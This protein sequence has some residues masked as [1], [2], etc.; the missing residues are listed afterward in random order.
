MP[1]RL[2]RW[3]GRSA[4]QIMGSLLPDFG[5]IM[6]K[7]LSFVKLLLERKTWREERFGKPRGLKSARQRT[8]SEV[9]R[10]SEGLYRQIIMGQ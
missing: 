9:R 3:C 2:V 6:V 1:D 10:L 7:E 4:T 5:G 8:A